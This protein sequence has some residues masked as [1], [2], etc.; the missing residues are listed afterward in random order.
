MG[1]YA[2][3][4]YYVICKNKK[5]AKQVAKT[6]KAMKEDEH[7]NTY[8]EHPIEVYDTQVESFLSSV[9]YQNLEYKCE[10]I[11]NAIKGI[12]GVEEANFPFLSEADGQYFSNDNQ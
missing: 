6:I 3:T 7:G 11:W 10:Q 5:I 1:V 9:R 8:N 4:N 12:K 2:Q